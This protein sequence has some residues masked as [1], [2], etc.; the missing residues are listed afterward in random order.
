MKN[1]IYTVAFFL[2]SLPLCA[3]T[4]SGV[5]SPVVTRS[6]DNSRTG[7]NTRETTLTQANVEQRG[8]RRLTSLVMDGD[9][10]GVEAQPLILPKVKMKD[11][12]LR[13]VVVL[14]S[15]NNSVRAFDAN[16][17]EVLWTVSLGT[18]IKGSAAIDMHLINDHWGILSTGVIDVQTQILYVVAWISPDGTPQKGTHSIFSL[19]LADGSFANPAVSLKDVTY[20]TPSGSVQKYGDSMRKQRTSLALALVGGRKT[21]FFASGTVLET[22][23]G[24]AGWIFAY[25]VATNKISAALAMSAGYGAGIWMAGSGLCVDSDGFIY[26]S[27]GNGSFDAKNDWGETIFK[28]KYDYAA[29]SLA[30]V[31]WWTPYTDSGRVGKDPTKSFPAPAQPKLAG[32]SEP[33]EEAKTGETQTTETPRPVNSM[34]ERDLKNARVV[35]PLMYVKPLNI[36]TGAYSDED[37]GSAGVSLI[38]EYGAVLASGKDGIAYLVKQHDM[39]KTVPAD[40]AH[41]ATNYAKL[42]QPP[43]WYTYYPGQIDP[44]PQNSSTLDFL[45]QGKTRHMH[46]TSVQYKSPIHGKML[47]CWGENSNLR[48][49][50]MAPN[51]KLIYLAESAEIASVNSRNSPGGMPGGFMSLSSNRNKPGTAVLWALIPYGDANST[52]TNGRLIAYDPDNF[53]TYSDGSKGL[54]VLWDSERFAIQFI[55]NK[56]NVPVV[57]GG[58]IFVPTYDGKVDVY[59]LS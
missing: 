30:V 23:G 37:L 39:G 20:T 24:A 32:V 2:L 8:I 16:T 48:A 26:G 21:I 54:R 51:G 17:Y 15:M 36:N 55:Y 7:A 9:A 31:D 56:F 47:F 18:P 10:R 25:D 46:S 38:S 35:G 41:A 57:S 19:H 49:W 33:S 59:G 44:A 5:M 13:D 22:V 43:Y 11:G 14:C 12:K 34:A 42:L 40:F 29:K 1:A 27:T 3:Q 58:K 6:Y 50:G 52:V 4:V 28:V 45:F 53:V